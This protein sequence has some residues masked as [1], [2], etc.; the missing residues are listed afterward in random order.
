[1]RVPAQGRPVKIGTQRKRQYPIYR[2]DPHPEAPG[3]QETE[4]SVY[5]FCNGTDKGYK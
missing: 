4:S 3:G 5:T 2:P 1:M